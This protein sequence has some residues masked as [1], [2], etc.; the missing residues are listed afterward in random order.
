MKKAAKKG[1]ANRTLEKTFPQLKSYLKLGDSVLDVGC[2]PG[3]ITMSVAKYVK[4]GNVIG[5]DRQEDFRDYNRE[6][7][8]SQATEEAEK[9]KLSNV[10]F[11][12][13][14]AHNLDF[15]DATFDVVYSH[16]VFQYLIDPVIALKEQKRVTKKGGWVVVK[17]ADEG[18]SIMHPPCPSYE[19]FLETKIRYAEYLKAKFNAGDVSHGNYIDSQ[20]GRK[21]VEWFM[22]AGL[23][24]LKM[25]SVPGSLPD[26]YPGTEGFESKGLLRRVDL[27]GRF[28]DFLKAM[29]NAG[30][31]D[32]ET[33]KHTYQ[34]IEAWYGKPYACLFRAGV[35]AAGKA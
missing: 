20:P 26:Q 35:V 13:S 32:E 5:V 4:P 3:S 14:D 29:I 18:F 19:K 7:W 31:I 8:V 34:E 33:L 30:F 12:H 22:K 10:T 25:E 1:L 17:V 15:P 27:D 11:K 28:G 23:K 2:G 24:E 16:E 21:C 9:Q 6:D